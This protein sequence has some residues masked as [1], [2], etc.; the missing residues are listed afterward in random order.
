[1][2]EE[3]FFDEAIGFVGIHCLV[4]GKKMK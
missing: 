2:E 1:V 4:R 3:V